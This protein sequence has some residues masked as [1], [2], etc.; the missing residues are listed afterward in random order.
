MNSPSPAAQEERERA[1]SRDYPR[2]AS[3]PAI[4]DDVVTTPSRFRALPRIA[5]RRR[6]RWAELFSERR[7]RAQAGALGRDHRGYYM[8][9]FLAFSDCIAILVAGGWLV[10]IDPLLQAP[11]APS[12]PL[13]LAPVALLTWVV[14][15]AVSGMYHVDEKRLE[16]S[17]AD[18]IGRVIQITAV[19]TWL[20]FLVDTLGAEGTT[21][22]TPA[23]LLWVFLV[24]AILLG[25]A[26][27]RRLAQK[28]PWYRQSAFVVGSPGDVELVCRVLDRHP[29][30]GV[31]VQRR[32][33]LDPGVGISR[34][35]SLL[36]LAESSNIDR[37]IFASTYEGLDER[38]GALRYLAEQGVK[39]DLVPGDSEVFRSD[40][41][42]HFIEGLPV[43]TLPMTGRPR[44]SSVAKRTIDVALASVGLVLAAPFF[45]FAAARIKLNS[46]GPVFFRQTRIGKDG[47]SFEV[48]K[49]RTMAVDADERKSEVARLNTRTDGMFKITE[50]PRVTSF[51]A[52]LRRY[53]LDELPQ[54][55]NVIRGEMSLV[56][57]RP[58]IEAEGN[59]VEEHYLARYN[60]RPGITGPWQVL[61]RSDIP[62]RDMLKLDYTYVTNWT[63][64]DDAKLLLRTISAIAQGRG[65]Y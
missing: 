39:V 19:W 48:V 46:R 31:E 35:D 38:T 51:G 26:L 42:L 62:F 22:V 57:P 4:S 44:S 8:R 40:A 18:E 6:R 30:Y 17:V 55:V 52:T 28:R 49:F 56:G 2:V 20:L 37:V 65:A 53:S 45:A 1:W 33:T 50:D 24:P 23:I 3:E 25:R 21:P 43:L 29:E 10:A 13:I 61:G 41:E 9:R 60:V 63:I 11:S 12:Q 27:T 47:S 59:L 5:S 14:L 16:C 64:G 58:L 7:H 54:L 32:L 15:A 36:D 34:V